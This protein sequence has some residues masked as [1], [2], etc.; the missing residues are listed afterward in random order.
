MRARAVKTRFHDLKID[1]K[2]YR[3]VMD[4]TKR[5]EIRRD[6]RGGFAAGDWLRLREFD[7]ET[8]TFVDSVPILAEVV[9]VQACEGFLPA[10]YVMLSLGAVGMGPLVQFR[11][12]R[13]V[14]SL[15]NRRQLGWRKV[16]RPGAVVKSVPV[17]RKS[18][19]QK[20][21]IDMVQRY[22][23][24]ALARAGVSGFGPDDMIRIDIGHF[25][26]T[27]EMVVRLLKIGTLP[28]GNKK[29]EKRGTKRDVH[30]LI[31]LV[32]DAL[33][34]V[35]WHDDSQVESASQMRIRK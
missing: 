18:G 24:V 7:R 2:H 26:R 8:A 23:R 14:E 3:A 35:A 31:E 34:H 13:P 30:G 12:P 10:G 27:N 21:D 33:N 6:D 9:G 20:A 15:K 17:T 4:G 29:G 32:C 25:V 1:P 28:T 19:E 5:A 11:L 16:V 22:A